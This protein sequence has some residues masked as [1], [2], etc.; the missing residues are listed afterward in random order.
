MAAAGEE[1]YSIIVTA[2]FT[3][4]HAVEMSATR[5]REIDG[6]WLDPTYTSKRLH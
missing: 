5:V 4:H 6:R 3:L 2:V 1:A